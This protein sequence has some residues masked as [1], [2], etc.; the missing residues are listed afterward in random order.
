MT[1]ETRTLDSEFYETITQKVID[2][3]ETHG[4]DWTRPWTRAMSGYPRNVIT[5][6]EYR[7]INIMNLAMTTAA[8]GW[9]ASYFA[10]KKQWESIRGKVNPDATPVPVVFFK[11]TANNKA[12]FRVWDVYNVDDVT[13]I[14][15]VEPER[16]AKNSAERLT[17]V[18]EWV[19][20]TGARIKHQGSTA[21]YIP[22]WDEIH[23]PKF[24]DFHGVPEYYGT[25]LHELVHWTGNKDRLNR[26]AHSRFGDEEYAKEEL[27]AELGAAFLSVQHGVTSEPREDHAKY[28]NHWIR[29]LKEHPKAIFTASA[30]AQKAVTFMND[31]VYNT[32]V[33]EA[34]DTI[35]E[36]A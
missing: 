11:P 21:C 35:A 6:A 31:L 19:E 7:G 10:S 34:T 25:L 14:L 33:D 9:S 5:G 28:L 30:K 27:V 22:S 15:M 3:M 12:I 1:T 13:D 26:I 23:M 29:V 18:E 4:T 24:E 32:D 36:V 16:T 17:A 8:M 20:G 2:L